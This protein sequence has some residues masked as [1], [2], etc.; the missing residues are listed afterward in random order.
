[1]TAMEIVSL[2]LAYLLGSIPVGYLL[3]RF[4]S[5]ADIRQAGSGGTGATNVLRNEGKAAGLFTFGL[6]ILKGFLA[7]MVT[8]WLTGAGMDTTWMVAAAAVVAMIGHIFPVWLGFRAGKGVATGVGVF[9]AITPIAVVCTLVV[10]F[11]IV[12]KTR[13]VSLGSIIAS[14]L[15]PLW[16][17]VWNGLIFP[18]AWLPQ[19]FAG[20]CGAIALIIFKHKDNIQRLL[21]GTENKFGAVQ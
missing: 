11:L 8:R 10:F 18:S 13:Y 4:R 1:M 14:A 2:A 17:W 9:L 16:A 6:D 12:K 19:I 5:G 20:L 21:N 3:V 15:M 7:V